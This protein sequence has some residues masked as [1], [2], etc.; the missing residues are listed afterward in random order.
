MVIIQNFI[1]TGRT[2]NM[3]FKKTFI[4]LTIVLGL[5][6]TISTAKADGIDINRAT[7]QCYAHTSLSSIKLIDYD[8]IWLDPTLDYKY[9]LEKD[10]KNVNQDSAWLKTVWKFHDIYRQSLEK[11]AKGETDIC[12]K[13]VEHTEYL[14][15]G[16]KMLKNKYWNKD[17][18]DFYESTLFNNHSISHILMAYGVAIQQI[19]VD[20]DTHQMIGESFKKAVKSNKRTYCGSCKTKINNHHLS[21]ARAFALYGTIFDDDKAVAT[22]RSLLNKYYKTMTKEGALRFEAMRG[23]RALYY[24]GKTITIIISILNIL[25]DGGEQAWTEQETA[26]VI[27]AV[28]FYIDASNDHMKIYKWAKQKRH[29]NKGDAKVQQMTHTQQGWVRPF[30]QRFESIHP[31]L[32][33]KILKQKDVRRYLQ[34]DARKSGDQ[35]SAIDSKCFFEFNTEYWNTN[36]SG[37]DATIPVKT[38]WGTTHIY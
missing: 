20:A 7:G 37:K 28:D 33:A 14:A 2:D 29:N 30:V 19:D 23:H 27:K 34:K 10:T 26:W 18:H 36:K 4:A 12:K 35:W 38:K 11:C 21:S 16:D 3:Y 9:S 22:A 25:E 31:E 8:K 24:T 5:L 1:H 32:V 13:I 6:I 17:G 15:S